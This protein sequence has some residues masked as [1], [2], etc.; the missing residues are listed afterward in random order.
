MKIP[1][2]IVVGLD[3]SEV[4]ADV[5]REALTLASTF[6]AELV[7]VH[8]IP[9]LDAD[10]REFAEQRDQAA[11]LFGDLATQARAGGMESVPELRVHPGPPA[12]ALLAAADRPGDLLLLG[13]AT[14]GR[15]DRFLLG[16]TAERL[17]RDATCPVWVVRP[18]R[19]HVELK[20]VLSAVDD[21]PAG[22]EALSA[23]IVL[24]RSLPAKL[25]LVHVLAEGAPKL[26]ESDRRKAPKALE[27]FDLH[28]VDVE[29]MFVEGEVQAGL[30]Q[31][32]VERSA[33][34]LV[35]GEARRRGLARLLRENTAEGL[36]R[37]CP[38]SL[39]AVAT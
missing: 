4:V 24:A 34:L 8:C 38:C 19:G 2:R 14:K 36:V 1:E 17:L 32:A 31:A 27:A 23:A 29:T 22:K 3:V 5:W 10:S 37:K 13:A 7:P 30:L 18:G 15:L 16:S 6:G 20:R 28:G 12:E 21:S 26:G 35:V 25:T 39:L 33:D 11:S 9:G